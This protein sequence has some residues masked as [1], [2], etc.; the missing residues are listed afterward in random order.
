MQNKLNLKSHITLYF[1]E[2][3]Y[4]SVAKFRVRCYGVVSR[5]SVS[6][7]ATRARFLTGQGFFNLYPSNGYVSFVLCRPRWSSGYH[8]RLWTGRVDGFFQSVKTLS[9]TSFG[10]EVKP[11]SCVVY[12]RQIKE[13]QAEIKASEQNLSD[14]SRSVS[15]ATLMTIGRAQTNLAKLLLAK[16]LLLKRAFFCTTWRTPIEQKAKVLSSTFWHVQLAKCFLVKRAKMCSKA[17]L[18]FARLMCASRIFNKR[19]HVL[20]KTLFPKATLLDWSAPVLNLTLQTK[21]EG[22]QSGT[23]L[24]QMRVS[25]GPRVSVAK[26]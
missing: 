16:A 4:I 10:R 19:K 7:P 13:P 25:S 1:I 22:G 5:F 3:K 11:W 14:F 26:T 2:I 17:F 18:L 12:L 21:M 8:T 9:M 23:Y 20:A 15:E 6:N 24:R